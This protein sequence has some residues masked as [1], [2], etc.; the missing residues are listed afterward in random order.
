M[1]LPWLPFLLLKVIL[2]VQP[3]GF[4]RN[5]R[6]MVQVL[7]QELQFELHILPGNEALPAES[8]H[9]GRNH[10]L[11]PPWGYPVCYGEV[12]LAWMSLQNVPF[13]LESLAVWWNILITSPF[14]FCGY[15]W[16]SVG[17]SWI[18]EKSQH[19]GYAWGMLSFNTWHCFRISL[20]L[21]H[22]PD[23]AS[24]EPDSEFMS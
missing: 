1:G 10:K 15:I 9:C 17:R 2:G 16:L 22:C 24:S 19:S 6:K 3:E 7:C 14:Q 21:H 8:P 11:Q 18:F 5:L 12:G 20:L 4:Q 23:L 13:L